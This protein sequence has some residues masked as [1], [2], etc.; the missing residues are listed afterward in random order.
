[1]SAILT[2]RS[3]LCPEVETNAVVVL[4]FLLSFLFFRYVFNA[5]SLTPEEEARK[6]RKSEKYFNK[7]QKENEEFFMCN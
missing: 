3:F 2:Q 6:K 1:M 5:K 4:V 7:Y